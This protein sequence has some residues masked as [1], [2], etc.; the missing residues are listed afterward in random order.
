MENA[1][2]FKKIKKGLLERALKIKNRL[3]VIGRKS[4]LFADIECLIQI[5]RFPRRSHREGVQNHPIPGR[6]L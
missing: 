5:V 1:Q 3:S 4:G 2:L 6:D